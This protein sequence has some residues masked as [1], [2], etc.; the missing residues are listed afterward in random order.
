MDFANEHF[1]GLLTADTLYRFFGRNAFGAPVGMT[2]HN[3]SGRGDSGA[4]AKAWGLGR[5]PGK[6]VCLGP[7]RRPAMRKFAGDAQCT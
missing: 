2:V 1:L 6:G 3:F 7:N 5:V 4:M